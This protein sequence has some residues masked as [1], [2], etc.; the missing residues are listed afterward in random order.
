MMETRI[1]IKMIV[2]G[3]DPASR[4]Q[5]F[6]VLA[7]EATDE[8]AGKAAARRFLTSDG[9]D[10]CGFDGESTRLRSLNEVRDTLRLLEPPIDGVIARSGRAW[11]EADDDE[12]A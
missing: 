10:L 6:Q 11:F 8:A 2:H 4:R 7:I 5:F 9:Y 3:K 12:K 1:L